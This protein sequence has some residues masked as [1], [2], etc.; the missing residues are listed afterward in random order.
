MC[1]TP[2]HEMWSSFPNWPA[3]NPLTT[4]LGVSCLWACPLVPVGTLHGSVPPHA[5][6]FDVCVRSKIKWQKTS[7]PRGLNQRACFSY[8]TETEKHWGTH[9]GRPTALRAGAPPDLPLLSSSWGSSIMAQG[10][11]WS[12]QL[13]HKCPSHQDGGRGK[14][15][16][17]V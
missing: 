11:C 15:G 6:G 12:F 7:H 1:L 16:S 2:R 10:D 4:L 3:A 9:L 17:P 14:R 5:V 8:V 13:S